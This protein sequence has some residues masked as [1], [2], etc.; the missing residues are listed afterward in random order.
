MAKTG[1]GVARKLWKRILHWFIGEETLNEASLEEDAREMQMGLQKQRD[2]ATQSMALAVAK[3]QELAQAVAQHEELKKTAKA[4]LQRGER[5]KAVRIAS[6]IMTS[7]KKME[8][9]STQYESLKLAAD[10]AIAAFRTN[11]EAVAVR[12][13]QLNELQEMQRIN[14][15]RQEAQK[16][17]DSFD[18]DSPLASFDKTAATISLKAK[19]LDAASALGDMEGKKLDLEIQQ[20]LREDQIRDTLR[21]L[22]MEMQEEPAEL[23]DEKKILGQSTV[24][25]AKALL[26]EPTFRSLGT[27]SAPPLEKPVTP[28]RA[29]NPNDS[30][31]E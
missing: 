23:F 31:E 9:L 3:K 1:K 7:E 24:N 16:A 26:G 8:S 19:Q 10:N 4:F 22:E 30:G 21:A 13:Q 11:A 27:V 6:Q 14:T 15:L 2:A 28:K 12:L 18:L 17:F 5:D 20:E 29:K 25:K